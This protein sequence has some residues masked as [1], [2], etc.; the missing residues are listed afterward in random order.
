MPPEKVALLD[1]LTILVNQIVKLESGQ[2]LE[3]VALEF[4]Q[5]GTSLVVQ[6]Y[7]MII[8]LSGMVA[9]RFDVYVEHHLVLDFLGRSLVVFRMMLIYGKT[10][11]KGTP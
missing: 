2:S 1:S 11:M 6:S 10:M 4:L 3:K 7:H 9:P 8:S 5:S